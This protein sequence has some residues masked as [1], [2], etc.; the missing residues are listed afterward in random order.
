MHP[1]CR[2]D[3]R[4]NAPEATEPC[5]RGFPVLADIKSCVC[6]S[7][8]GQVHGLEPQD[9]FN[10]F[11]C[12]AKAS[13]SAGCQEA[14]CLHKRVGQAGVA[15]SIRQEA[16]K[17]IVGEMAM[18]TVGRR[19]DEVSIVT[20]ATCRICSRFFHLHHEALPSLPPPSPL[21]S[22]PPSSSP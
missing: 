21:S 17:K 3:R 14:S 1:W 10:C 22:S 15:G 5:T 11:Y 4:L 13:P 18:G 6:A 7:P 12:V 20:T 8:I 19:N 16:E 2:L 9:Q